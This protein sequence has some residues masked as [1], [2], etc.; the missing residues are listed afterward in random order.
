MSKNP[1]MQRNPELLLNYH[2]DSVMI[3][4]DGIEIEDNAISS[5]ACY[6]FMIFKKSKKS[7]I[8]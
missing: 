1:A 5:V 3:V 6:D 8:K 2:N 7:N 4:L